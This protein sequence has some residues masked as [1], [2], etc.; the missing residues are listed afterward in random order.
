MFEEALSDIGFLEHGDIGN[1]GY[2]RGCAASCK[3]EHPFQGSEFPVDGG[4][5]DAL[6]HSFLDVL[7]DPGGG[8]VRCPHSFEF[9]QEIPGTSLGL[10]EGP[11][12][13]DAVI[14]QVIF[15]QLVKA[16]AIKAD[17]R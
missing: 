9:F 12:V 1:L 14:R 10:I 11:F 16:D 3:V 17:P 15:D 6:I 13:V 8:D 2:P 4:I 5:G 7:F